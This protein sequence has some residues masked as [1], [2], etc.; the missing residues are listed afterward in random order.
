MPILELSLWMCIGTIILF[1]KLPAGIK[2][3]M[4]QYQVLTDLAVLIALYQMHND[5]VSGTIAAAITAGGFGGF[6]SLYAN[7]ARR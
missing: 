6:L 7:F 5:G 2:L 1:L 3:W 4:C